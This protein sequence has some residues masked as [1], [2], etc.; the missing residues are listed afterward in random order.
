[1]QRTIEKTERPK[2]LVVDGGE[3]F[4]EDKRFA[5]GMLLNYANDLTSADRKAFKTISGN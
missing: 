3:I 1:M 5:E 4:E 2:G